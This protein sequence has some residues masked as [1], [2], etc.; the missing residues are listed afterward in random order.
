[1]YIPIV[2]RQNKV[3]ENFLAAMLD[4]HTKTIHDQQPFL[5]VILYG[6][7]VPQSVM[8]FLEQVEKETM[9]ASTLSGMVNLL[10]VYGTM[11]LLLLVLLLVLRSLACLSP[12]NAKQKRP[13][14]MIVLR[15]LKPQC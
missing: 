9:A 8:Y 6:G 11:L 7:I 5:Q 15:L 10:A 3:L 13:P 4:S 2:G 14:C 12:V 1:M